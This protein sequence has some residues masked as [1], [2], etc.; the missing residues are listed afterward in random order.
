MSSNFIINAK[1]KS[2]NAKTHETWEHCNSLKPLKKPRRKRK[3]R[4]DQKSVTVIKLNPSPQFEPSS[5]MMK[6]MFI[7]WSNDEEEKIIPKNQC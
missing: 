7:N 2:A 5:V 3:G 4:S 6:F 1:Q